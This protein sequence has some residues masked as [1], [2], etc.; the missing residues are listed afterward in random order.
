M[1]EREGFEPSMLSIGSASCR[2]L[3]A[4]AAINARNAVRHC[5]PLPT[6]VRSAENC[7]HCRER[8]PWGTLMAGS[9]NEP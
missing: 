5:S 7:P 1:A 8:K 6:A 2:F 3:V 4:A 9:F